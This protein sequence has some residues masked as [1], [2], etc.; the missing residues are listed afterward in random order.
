[1]A[2]IIIEWA[3]VKRKEEASVGKKMEQV[4]LSVHTVPQ[5]SFYYWFSPPA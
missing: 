5:F 3:E 4:M 2:P 1:M